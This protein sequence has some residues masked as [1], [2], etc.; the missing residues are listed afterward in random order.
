VSNEAN[1]REREQWATPAD[2]EQGR[3]AML[4]QIER[5]R[6]WL[7]DSP[8]D[9]LEE[10]FRHEWLSMSRGYCQYRPD[11]W[12]DAK[13]THEFDMR[14]FVRA[15]ADGW[16]VSKTI[17]GVLKGKPLVIPDPRDIGDIPW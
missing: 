5:I 17:R 9:V 14:E 13:A 4:E 10:R 16:I 3:S 1:R 8:P 12:R 15:I 6:Q 11:Q 2:I 7:T